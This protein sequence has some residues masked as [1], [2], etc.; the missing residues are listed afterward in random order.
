MDNQAIPRWSI[1]IVVALLALILMSLVFGLVIP[2]YNKLSLSQAMT[3]EFLRQI[4]REMTQ[5]A[6]Y[7]ETT[8]AVSLRRT[9]QYATFEARQLAVATETFTPSITRTNTLTFD[10]LRATAYSDETNAAPTPIETASA[11]SQMATRMIVIA[12]VEAVQTALR[13]R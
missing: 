3:S 4:E 7:S 1:Y 9:S 6:Y 5:S 13:N 8:G 2:E 10:L 11:D 12:T